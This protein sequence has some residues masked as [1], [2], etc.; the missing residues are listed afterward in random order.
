VHCDVAIFQWLINYIKEDQK[1]ELDIKNVI[2][3]L[4][5]SEFLGM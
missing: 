1:P 4:I 5:S 2:S 3:I